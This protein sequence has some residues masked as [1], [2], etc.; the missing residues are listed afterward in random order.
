MKFQSHVDRNC[1]NRQNLN[2][3]PRTVIVEYNGQEETLAIGQCAGGAS[4]FKPRA[5]V[6]FFRQASCR[7][8]GIEQPFRHL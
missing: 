1:G 3:K 5:S 7:K 6:T 4:L 2:L 8:L